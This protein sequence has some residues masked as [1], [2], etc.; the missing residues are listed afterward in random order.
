MFLSATGEIRVETAG[1]DVSYTLP[2]RP[3]GNLRWFGLIPVAFSFLFISFP[4][5]MIAQSLGRILDR[6]RPDP[7]NL[8]F[9]IFLVP[10]V[11]VGFIPLWIGLVIIAGRCRVDWR[12]RRLSVLDHV[13]P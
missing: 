5:R 8:I 10:F 2:P 11:V 7:G 3:F 1:N 12:N 9:L 6:G 4:F 13:G